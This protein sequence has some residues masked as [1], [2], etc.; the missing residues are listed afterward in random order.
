M[1]GKIDNTN[2]PK[3][4]VIMGAY[5]AQKRLKKSVESIINQDFKNWELIICDDGSTDDTYLYILE[6][7]KKDTRGLAYTLNHCISVSRGEFLARMDDDDYSYPNRF[8]IQYEFLCSHPEVAIVGSAACLVDSKAVWGEMYRPEYPTKYN[9]WEGKSFIHPTVMM[10]KDAVIISGLYSVGKY[11][12][13][14][15]DYDMWCKMYAAGFQAYNLQEKLL[16]YYEDRTSFSKRKYIYRVYSTKLKLMWRK[17]LD[18]PASKIFVAF[19]PM[20]H[21]LVPTCFMK[22]IRMIKFGR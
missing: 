10:R 16:D 15:E 7:A 21:G 20:L 4:S 2:P 14:T 18:V 17:S 8:T 9:I 13:R 3:I 1:M 5:N 11:V 19:K 22:K 6:L 12:G